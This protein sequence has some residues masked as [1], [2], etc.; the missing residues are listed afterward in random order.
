MRG[1]NRFWIIMNTFEIL[2]Q[3]NKYKFKMINNF[4]GLCVLIVNKANIF[5]VL[6]LSIG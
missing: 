1:K 5:H 3:V 6:L 4:I 2:F